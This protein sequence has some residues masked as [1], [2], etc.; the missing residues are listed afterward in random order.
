MSTKA[1]VTLAAS[2]VVSIGAIYYVHNQ[3]EVEQKRMH[4]GVIK[5]IERQKY[6]QSLKEITNN[7]SIT[8]DEE[9]TSSVT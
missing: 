8:S 5:D 9:N 7:E 6:K 1:I 4:L 3:Q 2:V